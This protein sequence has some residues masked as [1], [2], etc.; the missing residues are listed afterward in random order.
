MSNFNFKNSE[1]SQINVEISDPL[2]NSIYRNHS[3][4]PDKLQKLFSSILDHKWVENNPQWNT[5]DWILHSYDNLGI[6]GL[7]IPSYQLL[8]IDPEQIINYPNQILTSK[9]ESIRGKLKG[10]YPKISSSLKFI[11]NGNDEINQSNQ[12]RRV[13]LDDD[14]EISAYI[15]ELDEAELLAE[16]RKRKNKAKKKKGKRKSGSSSARRESFKIEKE[17]NMKE[18]AEAQKD[19]EEENGSL[20][21]QGGDSEYEAEIE[22][23]LGENAI[24]ENSSQEGSYV[25]RL[26]A[27]QDEGMDEEPSS[28]GMIEEILDASSSSVG[29]SIDENMSLGVEEPQAVEEGTESIEGSLVSYSPIPKAENQTENPSNTSEHGQDTQNIHEI[30]NLDPTSLI[31]PS[32]SSIVVKLPDTSFEDL[33]ERQP[34]PVIHNSRFPNNVIFFGSVPTDYYQSKKQE[35]SRP[36]LN[37]LFPFSEEADQASRSF[38]IEEVEDHIRSIIN[39]HTI[40]LTRELSAAEEEIVTPRITALLDSFQD[41]ATGPRQPITATNEAIMLNHTPPQSPPSPN[42]ADLPSSEGSRLHNKPVVLPF[43]AAEP[44]L[45]PPLDVEEDEEDAPLVFPSD[46]PRVPQLPKLDRQIL[47][48]SVFKSPHV[49]SITIDT[50][51]LPS[52]TATVHPLTYSWTLYYSNTSRQRKVSTSS[53]IQPSPLGPGFQVDAVD[54]SS[55][56]FTIF[57]A[58]NLEDLFGSWK[59]LRRSIAN[60]K[61]RNIEPLGDSTMKGG[62]GIGTHFFPEETN[63][64]FFRSGIKPMWEDKICQKGGKI[65]IAGEALTMDN[66]F[67]EC[68]L[69]L[70][71]GELDELVPVPADST[72]TICGVVL[73]RRKLTRIEFWLG[74]KDGPEKEWVGHVTR[75]I[76]TRFRGSKV[77]GYKPFGKN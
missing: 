28:E 47:P 2:L 67:L 45:T 49:P 26:E 48:P 12:K 18:Q 37:E 77:Y 1:D 32:P 38:D 51:T 70:I 30:D 63:F 42:S 35:Q 31:F 7:N 27:K 54:Y 62:S 72:S 39:H 73:S 9:N 21:V 61:G 60:T 33:E 52:F 34:A 40:S 58:N 8:R 43:P 22:A 56:L 53:P 68:V 19:K 66:I 57:T 36:S 20:N 71:S 16:N 50:P 69:L 75:F 44:P 14:E 25:Q 59:A 3:N 11:Q 4:D 65:M 41:L 6:P 10:N 76:E 23:I 13:K 15:A 29:G 64:H 5:N 24:S 17:N 74:G 55:H 46:P